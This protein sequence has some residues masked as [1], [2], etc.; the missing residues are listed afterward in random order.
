[1]GTQVNIR[2]YEPGDIVEVVEL[3]NRNLVAD[4]LMSEA[5]QRKALLDQNYDARGSLVAC[6][7]EKIVGY[8]LGMVRRFPLEDGPPDFGRS[9]I[10]LLA[11]DVQY[12]RMGIGIGLVSGL[13]NYFRA[14][15]CNVTIISGYA[16]NYFMPG[17]DPA[18]YPEALEFFKSVGFGE[19]Y[20]PLSMDADLLKLATPDWVPA[21]E[22]GL[23]DAGV[24]FEPYNPELILPLLDFM[25][26]EFPGDW[27]RFLRDAM[28]RI[29]TGEYHP[30]NLWIAH[31]DGRALGFAMHDNNCRFGPFG[32]AAKERGRGL[33][34][35]L[36]LRILYSMK[37]KGLHNA[38]FLW[39][40]E[41]AA[42][43][44]DVGGFKESRRFAYMRKSIE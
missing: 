23:I 40:D 27:Q 11:V 36:L 25:R 32:V 6:C 38:W 13:E 15:N 28:T 44:Y 33:G 22:Q 21:K 42:R 29:T 8:A 24:V 34:V 16:P 19:V 18:A 14:C 7:G 4:P 26:Q 5:F 1:M 3:L 10:T 9:W 43:V 20:R 39:T 35:V 30:T 2:P 31:T 17:V 41:A 12:R 37:A